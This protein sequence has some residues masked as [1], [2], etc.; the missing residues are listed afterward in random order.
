MLYRF[1][2]CHLVNRN[3]KRF[4]TTKV[5]KKKRKQD[6]NYGNIGRGYDVS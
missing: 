4:K 6:G 3:K 5:D 1:F 2:Q